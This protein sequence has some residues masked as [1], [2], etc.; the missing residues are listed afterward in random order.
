[1]AAVGEPGDV[2]DGRH[3]QL[4]GPERAD[5]VELHQAAAG[6]SDQLGEFLV[7][8]LLAL[9]DPLQVGDQLGCDAAPGL[10]GGV[11]WAD[12]HQQGLGLSSGQVAFRS[13]RDQPE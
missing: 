1:M 7:G 2:G 12:L 10:A 13:A 5:A 8:R 9:V 3:E 11:A 6:G 4:R